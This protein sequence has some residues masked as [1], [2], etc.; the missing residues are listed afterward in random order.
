MSDTNPTDYLDALNHFVG[1]GNPGSRYWFCGIEE[2][3]DV[4]NKDEET[5]LDRINMVYKNKFNK[6]GFTLNQTDFNIFYEKH[7]NQKE[8][9]NNVAINNP[10]YKGILKLYNNLV[11]ENFL[12]ERI[13]EIFNNEIFV[14]N[15]YPLG[16]KDEK[17]EYSNFVNKNFG[18]KNFKEWE[19]WG[20]LR[21]K[22]MKTFL[23]S[24]L[25]LGEEKI[26]IC[27]G[28]GN[29]N[30]FQ[31]IFNVIFCK[32]DLEGKWTGKSNMYFG[33][34]KIFDFNIICIYHPSRFC[35]R[36]FKQVFN[37]L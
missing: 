8:K 3:W 22:V 17:S 34:T 12:P 35:D 9:D 29:W 15:L 11:N 5:E 28:T 7:R 30:S 10:T 31:D 18:C 25:S 33:H 20:D 13:P 4:S 32:I 26:I 1:Y 37:K 24:Y 2:R 21:K 16:K 23:T 6:N 36:Y 19:K 14:F 27:L